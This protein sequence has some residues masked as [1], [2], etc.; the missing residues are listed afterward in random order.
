[1]IA[2][3]ESSPFCTEIERSVMRRIRGLAI[4]LALFAAASVT[5]S[6]Q[7]RTPRVELTGTY[8]V[9]VADIDFLNNETLHGWGFSVQGNFTKYFGVVAEFGGTYGHSTI[10]PVA[11]PLPTPLEPVPGSIEVNTRFTTFLFGPRFAWR[12]DKMTAFGHVLVGGSVNH[13]GGHPDIESDNTEFAM[14]LGGGLDINLSKNWAIRAGQ[15]DYLPIHSD[16]P[17]NFHDSSYFRNFRYQTGIVY[18]F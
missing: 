2:P 5:A 11:A 13:V 12:R 17:L 16:L 4:L 1:M 6:A 8:A 10:P 7:D 3:G 15:F 18:K 9:T 14:A